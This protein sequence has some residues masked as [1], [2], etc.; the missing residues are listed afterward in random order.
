M[1]DAHPVA[2]RGEY[3]RP[4]FV[5]ADWMCL[6]GTW[7]FERDPNRSGRERGLG[8]PTGVYRES[9][10][11]PFCLES[12][13]SG[14]GET[15]F[16]AAVW[17]RRDFE[18]PPDWLGKRILLHFGA[19]DYRAEVFIN[20]N[21]VGVHQ[22]GFAPFTFDI[23][24]WLNPGANML[25]VCAEDDLR[26]G[27]QARGKQSK[28]YQSYG[29]YY[30]RTTG[31]WQTVWLEPVPTASLENVKFYP[32]PT[33]QKVLVEVAIRGADQDGKEMQVDLEARFDG[34]AL[35]WA[36]Q[37]VRGSVVRLELSLD[38]YHAWQLGSPNLYD[39]S[40]RLRKMGGIVD[41]VETYFGLREV[42]LGA[43]GVFINGIPVFQR[44]VLDQG[45]YPDGVYTAPSDEDIKRDILLA[46]S[47]G[48][49]G[50][51]LHQKV[52][53]PRY[54][55]WADRLGYL[56]W[57]EYPS[58][59]LDVSNPESLTRFLPEWLD[60][61]QRDFNHP[62]I[63]LWCPFNETWDRYHDKHARQDDEILR[64]VYQVTKVVDPTRPVIDTSG[65][66]HVATDIFDI[67]DYEQDPTIFAS[68]FEPLKSGGEPYVPYADRQAYQG[69][70]YIVSEYGGSWW[71]AKG[72]SEGG[73]GYGRHASSTEEF[74]ATYEG[75]TRTLLDNPGI[76]GFCYTQLYDVEQEK[77]GL[78]TYAREPKFDEDG[79]RRIRRVNGEPSAFERNGPPQKG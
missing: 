23:S 10:L 50:A 16:M 32:D 76:S 15:D 52:F 66:F 49:N 7:E 8:T 11:V 24:P 74:L 42:S 4:Q 18:L 59:G 67:H 14:I 58:W 9:I 78:Y 47:L 40:I 33:N 79:L 35:G 75:L 48:F 64:A 69:Q 46:M 51:R 34:S 53:D 43:G 20:G 25:T 5:R 45:Y 38:E 62:S 61:V 71:G 39:V 29:C 56:V 41:Q 30:T 17:Y 21:S 3:P 72:D 26:R 60:V 57:G 28:L 22:G 65:A 2:V 54:L 68:H 12:Q 63:V 13:Q 55:Y 44:L 31:I 73:W 70:P 36:S 19:V 37:G 77:N 27:N 1:H 6:N